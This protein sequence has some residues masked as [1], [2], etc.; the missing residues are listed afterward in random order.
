MPVVPGFHWLACASNLLIQN[1]QI[2]N[3]FFLI[4]EKE[5]LE[6][7]F[8]LSADRFKIVLF[9]VITGFDPNFVPDLSQT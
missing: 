6:Q 1:Q 2:R 3:I 9:L 5:N 8:S 4:E 7:P